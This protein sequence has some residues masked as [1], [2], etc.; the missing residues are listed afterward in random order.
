MHYCTRLITPRV[1]FALELVMVICCLVA[2]FAR[3]LPGGIPESLSTYLSARITVTNLL[4]AA[5][6]LSVWGFV[7]QSGG[8]YERNPSHFLRELLITTAA[9]V[10]AAAV[11]YV[12]FGDDHRGA[13]RLD[14][15]VCVWVLMTLG[16]LFVRT[17]VALIA[18]PAWA[19][20]RNRRTV[21]VVGTGPLARR[22]YRDIRTKLHRTHKLLGFVDAHAELCTAD[23][24]TLF[25]GKVDDLESILL[26]NAVDEVV[27]ALPARSCYREIE[28]AVRICSRA[29]IDVMYPEDLLPRRYSSP[30]WAGEPGV[31]VLRAA[32]DDSRLFV[33]RCVDIALALA[34]LIVLAPV[35]ITVAMAIK[36]TS[37]GP[38]VFTQERFGMGRRRFRMYKFR[39]MVMDA[40]ERMKALESMNEAKGPIFKIRNDPRIT[41]VGRFLRRTSLDE[42]PQLFNVLV[43]HMSL[44][45]PR[46]MSVRD[47]LLFDQSWLMRR[48]SVKPGLT[49]LWQVQGRSNASFDRWI[50]LD[51]QYI[52]NW[53]LWLDA[54]ILARTIPAVLRGSGAV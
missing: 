12:S 28:Q 8:L 42:L 50:A 48:F 11:L 6:V 31:M 26:R 40:E 51:L 7:A 5:L 47:V 23:M 45:G 22:A 35:M 21:M 24:R 25:L 27:I 54:N 43:G 9:A 3:T 18:G 34:G 49:C 13:S 38:I 46:P 1:L 20:L 14:I 15:S 30:A 32:A 19:D 39:T 2:A 53:S 29:G 41:R 52:D 10:A 36:L 44:V 16:V 33:K 4:R 37:D 17:T